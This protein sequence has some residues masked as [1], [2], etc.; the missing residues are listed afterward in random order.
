MQSV[1]QLITDTRKWKN[2]VGTDIE[3][4]S[5]DVMLYDWYVEEAMD[6]DGDTFRDIKVKAKTNKSSGSG[7]KNY[8]TTR[9][10]KL[11]FYGDDQYNTKAWVQCNC[12]YFLYHCE[13]ALYDAQS[14]DIKYSNGNDPVEKNPRKIP[15]ICK[16]ILASLRAGAVKRPVNKSWVKQQK[17]VQRKE[18]DEKLKEKEKKLKLREA[19][20][21]KAIKQAKKDREKARK[22]M[23]KK[24]SK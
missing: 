5:R 21:E 10:V 17:N 6:V 13:V 1:R 2:M 9:T 15:I 18:R 12:P 11:R 16:H 19:A 22:E 23:Q 3:K 7:N 24:P 14:S 8:G 4:N 20:K